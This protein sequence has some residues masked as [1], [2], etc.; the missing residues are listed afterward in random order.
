MFSL[1]QPSPWDIK[2]SSDVL[3][4]RAV[5]CTFCEMR[6]YLQEFHTRDRPDSA[7]LWQPSG[8]LLGDPRYSFSPK[9]CAAP[10]SLSQKE[11]PK[12]PHHRPAASSSEIMEHVLEQMHIYIYIH[13][14]I[15]LE[16]RWHNWH[17]FLCPR[18]CAQVW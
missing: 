10:R 13:T 18:S 12:L 9:L 8:F 1:F 11:N 5:S 3:K 6:S 15:L 7:F 17:N 16:S 2:A 4:G 14:Y